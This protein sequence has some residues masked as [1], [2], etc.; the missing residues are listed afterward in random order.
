MNKFHTIGIDEFKK[1]FPLF[2][3]YQDKLIIADLDFSIRDRAPKP[4]LQ[5]APARLNQIVLI[6]ALQGESQMSVD[7]YP[8]KIAAN[9]FLIITPAHL[10]QATGMSPDFK[11][12]VLIIDPEFLQ[13]LRPHDVSP[14]ISNFMEMRKHPVTQFTSE[15]MQ[16]VLK[17]V[18]LIKEKI[19]LHNHLLHPAVMKVTFMTFLLEL[20]NIILGKYEALAPAKP[21]SRREEILNNF[22]ELLLEHC[23]EEHEVS[24]YADKLF[25]TPQYLSL[26]LKDI[27]GKTA[28]VLIDQAIVMEAKLLLRS[29]DYTIQQIADILHFA[30][31]STFGKFFKKNVGVSPL[32][33]KKRLVESY[34]V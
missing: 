25:I 16:H 21:S 34:V 27:T 8:Y 30:D 2:D 13:Q 32:E 1:T 3:N 26:V 4:N 11:A 18:A 23:K 5:S 12:K 31:Q 22:L 33:Y 14:S 7:Y 20:F 15:E 10:V 24:Y 17:Y 28:N 9:N 29:Q 6:F 19:H